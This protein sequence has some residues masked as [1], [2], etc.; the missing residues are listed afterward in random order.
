MSV[1]DSFFV[2]K[3]IT[4]NLFDRESELVYDSNKLTKILGLNL[5]KSFYISKLAIRETVYGIILICKEERD[6]YKNEHLDIVNAATAIISYTIKDIELSKVFKLQLKALQNGILETNSAYK[7]I[8]EQNVKILESD[9]V[10][11]EFLANISHELRTP[12]NA[13]IGFSD[14]LK[15][16][17]F[18]ELNEKQLEYINEIN[19]SGIH[20]LGMIN[21]LLDISKIEAH[22]MTL[23]KM[24]YQLSRSINEVVNVVNPLA[25]KKNIKITKNIPEEKLVIADYQKINQILYN[26]LSNAIKFTPDNGKIYIDTKFEKKYFQFSIKDSGIG[27][28]KENQV[29]IFEKFVQLEDAYVKQESSTGL[30][31]TITKNLVEMHDGK[32]TVGS[33]LEKGT[34]FTVKIPQ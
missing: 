5:F 16:K 30:G 22:A 4:E 23:N 27:I 1:G 29:K 6:Y 14:V 11:N 34:T 2:P 26:L 25:E 9:K 19:V 33:E 31:L 12:L 7:T 20:L 13:I 17:L 32:I 8:K 15:E 28:A 24:E 21:E 10:K 18:G 3:N